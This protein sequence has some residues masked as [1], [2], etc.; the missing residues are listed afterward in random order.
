MGKWLNA[1]FVQTE[2][3]GALEAVLRELLARAWGA[4][5]NGSACGAVRSPRWT[6]CRCAFAPSM[7]ASSWPRLGSR[8]RQPREKP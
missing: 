8:Y 7:C 4:S 2:D 5:T 1:G 6:G 3:L